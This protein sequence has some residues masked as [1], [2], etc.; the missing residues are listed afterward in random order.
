VILKNIS[1]AKAELSARMEVVRKGEE[2]KG[3]EVDSPLPSEI[4]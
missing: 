4:A 3:E 2:R 1:E